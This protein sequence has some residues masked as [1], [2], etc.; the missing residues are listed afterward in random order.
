MKIDR[1]LV[2]CEKLQF[3]GKSENKFRKPIVSDSR[4]L[5]KFPGI[6]HKNNWQHT[7]FLPETN[8]SKFQSLSTP[9]NEKTK[10]ILTHF[11]SS[12]KDPEDVN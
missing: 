11:L 5:E 8:P 4:D 10:Q 6:L 3:V 12:N 1:E 2:S 9:Q 7:E